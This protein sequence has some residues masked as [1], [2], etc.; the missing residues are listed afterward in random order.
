MY[1]IVKFFRGYLCLRVTGAAPERCLNAMT[2]QQIPFWGIQR[3]DAL[4][5]CFFVYRRD[6]ETI[7]RLAIRE[8]CTVEQTGA[9]GFAA[10][11][12]GLLRRP[13][14]LLGMLLALAGTFVLQNVV[15]S[16]NVTGNEGLHEE[17]VLHALEELG[18]HV[19]AWAPA[20]QSQEIRNRI[21]PLVPELEWLA[22]NRSGGKL[23]VLVTERRTVPEAQP[24]YAVANVVAARDGI[25]TEISVTEG[26][27]LCAVGT[28]VR[29]GQLLVSGY[30]DYGWIVRPVRASAEI[31][32]QT[33][34]AGT[35]LFPAERQDKRYT[36]ET[37]T[38]VTLILGR[39]RINLYGNSR[40]PVGNCDKMID[41]KI[42][43][44]PGY[45]FPVKLEIATYRAYT[46]EAVDV[47]PSVAEE[48]LSLA[49]RRLTLAQMTAGQIVSTESSVIES[50]GLYVLQAEST[51][52]ELI[53][54]TVPVGEIE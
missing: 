19:G 7:R 6:R 32:A 50:G 15:W 26:M 20:I 4:H 16:I 2:R 45:E 54:R 34:H 23:Q 21:L 5:Y 18:V 52:T 29:K 38:Q 42:L 37:W 31:Y 13:V 53:S 35:V 51:C 28:A 41:E 3:E 36:G 44:I 27:K 17:E 46:L 48:A 47:M 10:T 11:F 49:W 43:S 1:G 30:E 14:L 12:G 8:M 22:V 24:S 39:K 9:Y 33:W 25:L 40:I